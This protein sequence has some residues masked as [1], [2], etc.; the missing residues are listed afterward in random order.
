MGRVLYILITAPALLVLLLLVILALVSLTT[1]AINEYRLHVFASQLDQVDQMVPSNGSR[2]RLSAHIHVASSD[3][4]STFSAFR[5]YRMSHPLWSKESLLE[6]LRN[7]GFS[8]G[9]GK[10]T[11]KMPE[12]EFILHYWMLAL[13]MHSGAPASVLDFRFWS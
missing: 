7:L 4:A 1:V 9:M 12:S 5:Q 11:S 13:Q 6:A 2:I 8:E 3:E 10:G